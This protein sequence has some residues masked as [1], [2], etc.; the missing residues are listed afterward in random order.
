V[1]KTATCLLGKR[2]VGVIRREGPREPR[3]QLFLMFDDGTYFELYGDSIHLAGGVDRGG[4]AAVRRTFP[5][6]GDAKP[7]STVTEE[8]E[9][10]AR[11]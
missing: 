4:I 1:R 2:I 5:P 9:P 3:A 11:R 6:D 7:M 10:E 8:W